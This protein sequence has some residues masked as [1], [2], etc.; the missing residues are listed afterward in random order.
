VKAKPNTDQFK[1]YKDPSGFLE[2]GAAD[3]YD[4]L[5]KHLTKAVQPVFEA[6]VHREQ[7]VFRLPLDL[8][9]TLKREA[10]ERSM[11]TGLRVT[12]TELVEQSL[13][14]FFCS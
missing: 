9:N 2:G 10:Y 7:K 4:K 5:D 3:A 14:L 12:E 11:K 1:P 8:I 13:R 6:K